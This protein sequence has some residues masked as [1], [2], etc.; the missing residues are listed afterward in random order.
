MTTISVQEDI[1]YY[2]M[3]CSARYGLRCNILT[4]MPDSQ[5]KKLFNS[6]EIHD[7]WCT[8]NGLIVANEIVIGGIEKKEMLA[9]NRAP[10]L[11]I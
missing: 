4:K 3:A 8:Y 6:G 11:I 2:Y 5:F 10:A 7:Y 1:R 9:P